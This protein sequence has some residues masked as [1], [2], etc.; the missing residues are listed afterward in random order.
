MA[1]AYLEGIA[2]SNAEADEQSEPASCPTCGQPMPAA[3][4]EPAPARVPLGEIIQRRDA[5]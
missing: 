5:K 3:A 4:E 1:H 2:K